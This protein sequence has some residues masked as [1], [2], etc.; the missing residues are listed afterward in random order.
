MLQELIEI[1]Y[2]FLKK[3]FSYDFIHMTKPMAK[4]SSTINMNV[5]VVDDNEIINTS[6]K[7]TT[8]TRV[9]TT[10]KEVKSKKDQGAKYSSLW[11]GF[12]ALNLVNKQKESPMESVKNT[13]KLLNRQIDF[14]EAK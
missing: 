11:L 3:R 14:D 9:T 13:K 12:Q 2:F 1:L 6:Q 7:T 5:C 4:A 10:Q 8:S